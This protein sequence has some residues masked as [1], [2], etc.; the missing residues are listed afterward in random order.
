MN[1]CG[2]G[3]RGCGD[4]AQ[5]L[6]VGD[7]DN[8]WDTWNPTKSPPIPSIIEVS[9]ASDGDD[10]I[11]SLLSEVEV[12]K[13]RS[14]QHGMNLKQQQRQTHPG[15]YAAIDLDQHDLMFE[16]VED[17]GDDLR[18]QRR[19]ESQ[20]DSLACSSFDSRMGDT[21]LMWMDH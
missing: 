1:I 7:N 2:P 8:F 21:R 13:S 14:F 19:Q 20:L 16:I 18:E 6:Q 15:A 17:R 5:L 3:A 11:V 9:I 12:A 10:D 4:F